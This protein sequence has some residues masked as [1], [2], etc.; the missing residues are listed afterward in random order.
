MSEPPASRPSGA[1]GRSLSWL[2]R[3]WKWFK[4]PVAL[5]VLS[6]LYWA[7]RE[8]FGNLRDRRIEWHHL[9]IGLVLC[10]ASIVLTFIRW[11]LLVWAL[12]FPFKLRDALRLGFIGFLFNYVGPGGAGGDVVKAVMIA[13]EQKSRR[14][15]AAATVVIDRVLG[16]FSLFVVGAMA[17]F[18]PTDYVRLNA[19]RWYIVGIW[20]GAVVGLLGL[21]IVLHPAVPRSR[22]LNLLIHLPW[23]GKPIGDLIAALLLYQ[24]K[25]RVLV[26]GVLIGIV[27][28]FG[29]LS[30]F[31]FAGRA[32][33]P[34]GAIPD[35]ASHLQFIP[36]AELFGVVIPLPGGLGALEGAI[37][38]FYAMGMGKDAAANGI[39]TG[40]AYRVLTIVIAS[41][42]AVYYLTAR[43]EI[44]AAL[45]EST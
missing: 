12:E 22:P 9:L 6:V 33:S 28:H 7:N 8:S 26:L 41:V 11:Y 31:Y 32:V 25:R 38:H 16:L 13:R 29:T 35:Y 20:T 17:T 14:F 24:A 23:V 21:A 2:G 19:F 27:G 37:G 45:V 3:Q 43:R 40:V 42:G 5:A 36:M 10:A 18:V 4:W 39:L 30:A 34:A 15:V 1:A 44:D